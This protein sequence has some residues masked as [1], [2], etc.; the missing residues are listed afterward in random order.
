[1]NVLDRDWFNW[2]IDAD[3]QQQEAAAPQVLVVRSFLRYAV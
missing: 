3:P 1:M 2:S